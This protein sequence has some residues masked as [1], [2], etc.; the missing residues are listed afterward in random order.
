[1]ILY[2]ILTMSR[3]GSHAIINWMTKNLLGTQMDFSYKLSYYGE[4]KF[5]YINEANFDTNQTFRYLDDHA[6]N[7]KNILMCYENTYSN[8]TLLSNDNI[9]KNSYSLTY[10]SIVHSTNNKRVIILRDFFNL[11]ASRQNANENLVF[12]DRDGNPFLFDLGQEFINKWKDQAKSALEKKC[13]HIKYEDWLKSKTIRTEF[14]KDVFSIHETEGNDVVGTNSSF[15]E[16]KNYDER[17]K[18]VNFSDDFKNLIKK[19][20]ELY[21]LIG[22]LGYEYRKL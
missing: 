19:D 4:G 12:R 20:N 1:M 15:G 3:S 14:L 8:Y 16:N 2:E 7:A 21:Y 22:G 11:A 5:I 6:K 10:S 18:Q 9:Y 13:H 17:H